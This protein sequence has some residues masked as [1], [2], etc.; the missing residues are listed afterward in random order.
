MKKTHLAILILLSQGLLA[1]SLKVVTVGAPAVNRVFDPSGTITVEDHSAPIWTSGFLQ[2]RNFQGV[3]GA[4]AAGMYGYEYRIDLRDV[5]GTT[6]IPYITSL[7]VDFGP[8]VDT[9][10]FNGDGDPDDVY[11]IT[12][13]G[14]GNIGVSSATKSGNTITFNFSPPVAG[15]ASPGRGDSTFFFGVVSQFPRHEVT[16]TANNNLGAPLTLSA[17]APQHP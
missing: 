9:L 7:K 8:H 1:C 16:A 13:G 6:A 4:P 3:A 10:D 12:S 15:G 14:L 5:V 11:V 2:S 17:W